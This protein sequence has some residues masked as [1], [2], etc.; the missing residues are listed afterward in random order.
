MTA[1]N[2]MFG[3]VP[4]ADLD[5]M[6]EWYGRLLGAEPDFWPNDNEAVWKV[7]ESGWLYVVRDA[8]RRGGALFTMLIDDL[9]ATLAELSDRGIEAGEINEVPGKVRSAYVTDP[10]GNRIQ[11]GQSLQ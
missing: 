1:V 8:E 6:V 3:G 7:A 9:D 4:A 11:F 2:E 5:A 10:E